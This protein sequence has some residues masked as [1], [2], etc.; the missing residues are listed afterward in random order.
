MLDTINYELE[1]RVAQFRE[2]SCSYVISNRGWASHL[3]D[4]WSIIVSI[5]KFSIVIGF[6]RAY[7]SINRSRRCPITGVKLFV[8]GYLLLDIHVVY[9]SIKGALMAFFRNSE[10]LT[11]QL[12]WTLIH[13]PIFCQ[14]RPDFFREE[15]SRVKGFFFRNAS[16]SFQQFWKALPTSFPGHSR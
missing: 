16:H 8:I 5:T 15:V 12:G 6:P 10:R 9:K 14:A 1:P 11:L 13:F 7:L 2:W 4:F 3:C